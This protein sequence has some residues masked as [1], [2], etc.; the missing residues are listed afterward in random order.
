MARTR[1]WAAVT[2]VGLVYLA[3]GVFYSRTLVTWDDESAYLAL[4]QLAVTG[5][6]SLFQDEM[7]GQRMPLPFYVIGA[8][9]VVFGRNLWAA[10][11]VSL[12]LGLAVLLV[13][14]AVARRVGGDWAGVLAG[15]LVATQGAVVGYF[16]T[17]TYHSLT[18][19]ILMTA[20]W[21]L[22]REEFRSRALIGM[23]IASLLFFTRTN[24]FPALL[25]LFM[26][27]MCIARSRAERVAVTLVTIVPPAV[28]F[29]ADT[30][31]LKLLAHI[32]GLGYLVAPLG[33]RSIL[34]FS[35]V[36]VAGPREQIW[37]LVI[38]ARRYESWTVAVVGLLVVGILLAC[39]AQRPLGAAWSRSLILVAALLVWILGWHFL[40]FWMNFKLVP[41]YFP[42]FSPL[43]AVV[44]GTVFSDYLGRSELDRVAKF[45]VVSSLVAT[46]VVSVLWIR[47]PLMPRPIP[48]PFREDPIDMS[49]R[50][51]AALRQLV[52]SGTRVFLVAGALPAYLAGLNPYIQQLMSAGGTLAPADASEGVV[53]KSGVWSVADVELWLGNEVRYAIVSPE[54]LASLEEPRPEAVRLIRRLLSERF[55]EVRVVQRALGMDYRVYHRRATG[56]TR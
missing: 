40:M 18:A 32:P 8:S 21:A 24:L 30:T 4:G 12:G 41:A 23:A 29:L 35:A 33:Y 11:L 27:A 53:R 34:V 55:E 31:H 45:I 50:T 14:V 39:R 20:V 44:V 3:M 2:V 19:L 17:A 26:W 48:L 51:A 7:T 49:Y 6:I 28:F 36:D 16:A 9:Q 10:R 25:F 5:Q 42:S 56:V 13:T 22:L 47:H 46:L 1:L 52:P 38:F 15:S 54:Y 43:L 37:A